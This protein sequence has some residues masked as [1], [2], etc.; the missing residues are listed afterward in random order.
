MCIINYYRLILHWMIRFI[1]TLNNQLVITSNT[2]ILLIYIIYSS[3]LH[4]HY[5]SQSSLVVSW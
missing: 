2:A 4:K 1:N 5:D 3:L